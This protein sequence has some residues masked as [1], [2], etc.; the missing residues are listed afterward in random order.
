MTARFALSA[1]VGAAVLFVINGVLLVTSPAFD[2]AGR[3]HIALIRF[4][5]Y[6]VTGAVLM[7]FTCAGLLAARGLTGLTNRRWATLLILTLLASAVIL[8][9]YLWVYSP[10]AELITPP[11]SPR[12]QGFRTL[13]YA[14]E[15]VNSIQVALCLIAAMIANW[16]IRSR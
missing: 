13:H 9:D 6:Y 2:S 15:T 12:P 10:L 16:P 11:G 1:W 14:S 5:P 4:P 7:G 3:D 8:G